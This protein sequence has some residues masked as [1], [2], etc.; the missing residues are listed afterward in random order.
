MELGYQDL[1]SALFRFVEV[2]T[3]EKFEFAEN[4]EFQPDK[5]ITELD[6]YRKTQVLVVDDPDQESS[7]RGEVTQTVVYKEAFGSLSNEP[8]DFDSLFEDLREN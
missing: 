4:A 2:E 1:G 7:L 6:G 5:T 3:S 8:D